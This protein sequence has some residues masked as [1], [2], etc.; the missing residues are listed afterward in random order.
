MKQVNVSC[1][2]KTKSRNVV[3]I[4]LII[5]VFLFNFSHLKAAPAMG[6]NDKEKIPLIE[7]I[8]KISLKYNV[9]PTYDRTLLADIWVQYE[10]DEKTDINLKLKELLKGTSLEFKVF[11]DQY[12]ILYK[13]DAEGIESM[14]GMLKHLQSFIKANEEE[15]DK[16]E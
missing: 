4:S 8:M 13:V 16:E 3:W 15:L 11:E 12:F 1:I 6:E 5:M 14:R 10:K 9:Y 7:A 2:K